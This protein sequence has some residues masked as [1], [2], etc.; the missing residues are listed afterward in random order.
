VPT[1]L[2]SRSSEVQGLAASAR[3][4][5]ALEGERYVAR[6]GE[7]DERGRSSSSSEIAGGIDASR[8]MPAAS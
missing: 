2:G 4:P 1:S 3:G 6:N 7:D 5:P 8:R